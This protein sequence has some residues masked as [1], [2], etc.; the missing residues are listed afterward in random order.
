MNPSIRTSRLAIWGLIVSATFIM[1][2]ADTTSPPDGTQ[3]VRPGSFG[4]AHDGELGA[5]I[6]RFQ[7][8][9]VIITRHDEAGL[10]TITGWPNSVADL[11]N[12]VGDGDLMDFQE[13]P[14]TAGEVNAMI[15]N[16]DVSV[17][18]LA[19]GP[20]DRLCRDL[21]QAPVLYAGTGALR[22]TDNNFTE[23]GTEGGRGNSFGWHINGVLT[24]QL[25]GEQ[26]RYTES[27]RIVGNPQTGE[28]KEVV[29]SVAIN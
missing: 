17:Q 1:A 9:F 21:Q 29:L 4:A 20:D 2:C 7:D 13:K 12:E 23:T 22:R 18:I 19:L 5:G 6:F 15:S 28:F 11:C 14:H 27:V 24:S 16:R 26:V 8:E 3:Q 10:I 25:S